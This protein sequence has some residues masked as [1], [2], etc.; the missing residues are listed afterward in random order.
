MVKEKGDSFLFLES[1]MASQLDI[2]CPR[3]ACNDL[4]CRMLGC[5][6]FHSEGPCT[7]NAFCPKEVLH[8][9]FDSAPRVRVEP[10]LWCGRC[11]DCG[12]G[13]WQDGHTLPTRCMCRFSDRGTHSSWAMRSRPLQQMFQQ[14]DF[15]EMLQR[16]LWERAGDP[17]TNLTAPRWISSNRFSQRLL[18]LHMAASQ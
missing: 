1:Q 13:S 5:R 8:H 9:G 2:Y 16:C 3:N 6:A 14:N 17:T 4:D 10:I 11:M 18:M 15:P 7:L 12:R